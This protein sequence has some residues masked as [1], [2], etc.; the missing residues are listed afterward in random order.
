MAR[1]AQPAAPAVVAYEPAEED[2]PGTDK[3]VFCLVAEGAWDLPCELNTY[4][5][6]S[7]QCIENKS[8]ASSQPG[9]WELAKDRFIRLKNQLLY[10][11]LVQRSLIVT[12]RNAADDAEIGSFELSLLPLLHQQTK[13]GGEFTVKLTEPYFAKWFPETADA[14]LDPKAKA[15]A[16]AEPKAAPSAPAAENAVARPPPPPTKMKVWVSVD[17]LVGP[18]E[19]RTMWTTLAINIAGAFSLPPQLMALGR[20]PAGEVEAHPVK[21]RVT[22]F[23][24]TVQNGVLTAAE[25]AQGAAAANGTS[26]SE[27]SEEW[28]LNQQSTLP[29]VRFKADRRGHILRYCGAKFIRDCQRMLNDTGGVWLYFDA[30]EKP[31]T[32]PKKPNAPETGRLVRRCAS[33][34]WLNLRPLIQ[35]DCRSTE[36][37]CFLESLDASEPTPADAEVTMQSSRSFVR[38]ALELRSTLVAD[39]APEVNLKALLPTRKDVFPFQSSDGA[40]KSLAEAFELGIQTICNVCGK[41]VAGSAP[42]VLEDLKQEGRYE[43]VKLALRS[44]MI[45]VFRERLCKD[46]RAVPG[47]ILESAE[48]DELVAGTYNYLCSALAAT[49]QEQKFEESAGAKYE[50]RDAEGG[51]SKAGNLPPVFE[52]AEMS[53]DTY[54]NPVSAA[55]AESTAARRCRQAF[56]E[57]TSLKERN[58]RLA[59]EA[60]LVGNFGLAAQRLQSRLI[61]PDLQDDPKEW[62]RYAKLCARARGRQAAAEESLR[63]AV[64]LLASGKTQDEDVAVEVD[65][66]LACLLLERGRHDEA[67]AVFRVWHEKDFADPFFRFLLG[68]ALFLS[69]DNTGLSYLESAGKPRA[70]FQ[71]LRDHAA[72]QLKLRTLRSSDGPLS[73]AQFADCLERL[74]EFGVPD[75][76][77][78]FLDQCHIVTKDLNCEPLALIDAKALALAQDF[79]NAAAR[80]EPLLVSG[81]ASREA[82]RLAGECYLQIHDFDRAYQA[83]T[84]AMSFENKFSDPGMYIRLGAVLLMKKRWKQARDAFLRSIQFQ[85]TAEAWSGVAYAEY[86]CDELQTCY[87]ALIEAQLLDNERP[88]VWAQLCLAHVRMENLEAADHALRQCLAGNPLCDELLLEVTQVYNERGREPA[89]AAATARRLLQIKDLGQGHAALADALA[90]QG[91]TE[92]SVLESA[93]AISMLGDQPDLRK[94]IL[95]KAL[96]L[97]EDLGDV[98]LAESLYAVQK[99]A[100]EK[101]GLRVNSD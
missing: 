59:F 20:G 72:V 43:D 60:E 21:Y 50:E 79:H 63:Q 17:D 38:L 71:G 89:L 57:A 56:D 15:K 94:D 11:D 40:V 1:V 82:Y 19:D 26:D 3:A 24:E 41:G 23:R 98:A 88:D 69:C 55:V 49:L 91:E 5:V 54:L 39:E 64:R 32:D 13:V 51:F 30:E 87:E 84:Q 61:L 22:I 83:I 8:R 52:D 45:Q 93:L 92:K 47:R 33:R 31:A 25:Q 14:N 9:S 78:T 85:P 75:L 62:V 12:L 16:K 70:W 34:A 90:Q 68:L 73:A 58:A 65:L 28:C 67:L 86:R 95:A 4:V 42:A 96:K 97:C 27:L 46:T 48:K 7:G 80:L 37:C 36:S 66:M 29:S 77:F 101:E 74:L 76:A 6:F 53:Q 35:R 100:D 18:A 81:T 44:A 2:E 10:D 99:L